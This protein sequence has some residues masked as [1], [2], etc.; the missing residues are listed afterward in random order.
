MERDASI[1]M[2][3]FLQ[4]LPRV[5]H[6]H[7]DHES[8]RDRAD[9]VAHFTFAGRPLI[10]ACEVKS[11]GQPRHVRN[12]IN[13]FAHSFYADRNSYIPI[14]IAPF[15]SD[16]SQK[17]CRDAGIGY[18]DFEGNA[19]VDFDTVFIERK[20]PHQPKAERRALR[21]LFKP[22]SARILRALLRN[23]ARAWRIAELAEATEVSVGHVSTIGAALRDRDWAEHND[24]GLSLTDPDGLLD[25][26]VADYEPPEGRHLR[27][28]THRH[29]PALDSA[30]RAM[31][32]DRG[33]N[34]IALGSYSAAE[35]LAPYGRNP[36]HYFYADRAGF[37]M[38]VQALDLSPSEKG[39]NIIIRVPDDDGVFL[40]SINPEPQ[41]VCTS[42]VQTY[43]DLTHAGERGQEAADHLRRELLKWQ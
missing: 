40:D 36:N 28:Y 32:A 30:I 8:Q 38:L 37:N 20:V 12:A 17:L 22:K 19:L 11:S 26:W 41:I 16:Q 23:T 34:N 3:N 42:P 27:Y 35:W 39:G 43:L 6:I 10:A 25:A 33:A 2:E 31:M 13:H 24:G 1:A 7:L 5:D 18:L 15:L 4:Q 21:S 29:G 14:L 9:F